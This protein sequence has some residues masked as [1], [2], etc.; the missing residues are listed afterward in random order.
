M[1]PPRLALACLALGAV[2]APA[3]AYGNGRFPRAERLLEQGGDPEKL[4]LSATYGLLVTNDR[5]A[6][7]RHVCELGFAFAVAEIDPLVG[8][9]P[10]GSMLVKGSRSLNRAPPPYCSFEPMLGGM[11][12]DTVV[13][14]SLDATTPNRVVALSMERGDG[15]GVV[16]RLYESLDSG[17]TFTPFGR[18]L[19]E[20]LVTFGITLDLAPSNPPRLYATATG[21]DV[22]GIFARSDDDG[23]SFSTTVLPVET[24]ENPYIA[25]VDPANVDVL[26][27]RTDLWAP[28]DEGIY[29][30]NDALLYSD[31][32]GASFREIFR[33]RGKL[34]GFALSPDGSE[35]LIGYGDPVDPARVVDPAVL[36]IYRAS[37]TDLAFTKIYEGS[38]SCLAWTANGLY[39]CT[40]QG[41]RGFA[42]GIAPSSDFDLGVAEP[43]AP[44]LDLREVRGPVECAACT[45]TG[46]CEESW[47]TTCALFGSCDAGAP[48]NGTGGTDCSGGTGTSGGS[49]P[50][51]ASGAGG[52]ETGG[53][54]GPEKTDGSCGCR[55]AGLGPGRTALTWF[56]LLVAALGCPFLRRS[57]RRP[58][59]S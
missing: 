9:F 56:G 14:F 53:A 10:D 31:D 35:V 1:H 15:G 22:A 59:K 33:A 25:A 30:A 47:P 29:E 5:G 13:D 49:S 50:G 26:Y 36:G 58:A 48:T 38:V 4:V 39:A 51:G 45:T 28:N 34:F 37:T 18:P 24:E 46:A 11:G 2:L 7:W 23:E 43:F 16:N 3:P 17:R 12:T 44:L 21:R 57:R 6:E 55:A 19:P 8:V 32:G 20:E 40:S 54:Q 42:L 41:E 27:V 52:R